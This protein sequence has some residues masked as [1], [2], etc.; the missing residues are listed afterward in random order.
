[1]RAVFSSLLLFSLFSIN[2]AQEDLGVISQARVINVSSYYQ[3]WEMANTS[4]INEFS[5]PIFLYLPFGYAF[6]I[7]AHANFAKI[8]GDNVQ[9]ISGFTDTQIALNYHFENANLLFT[10]GINLPS[11]KKQLTLN[12]FLSSS[13]ISYSVFRFH[14]PNFGE[15]VGI[16][17]GF[18]WAL[19]LSD[20]V[21]AGI[22]ATYQLKEG[23]KPLETFSDE[24]DPGDEILLT[25]GMDFR[26]NNTT[27]LSTDV[28]FTNFNTDKIGENEIFSSGNKWVFNLQFR[29]NINFNE[30]WLFARYRSRSKNQLV[31]AGMLIDEQEKTTP[32]QVDVMAHY[33][34]RFRQTMYFRILAEARFFQDTSSDFSGARLF[35]LG[36]MPEFSLSRNVMLPVRFLFFSGNLKNK[37]DLNGFEAGL[38]L[39]MSF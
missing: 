15:G 20:N 19:P 23:F 17:P 28:I 1:M 30:L 11:G 10:L 22:G 7:T 6:N 12:E 26:L 29:K 8:T 27:S 39:T 36:I 5:T 31:Q 35:G 18:T 4:N 16:A 2:Y 33:R 14:V 13:L 9:G 32:N 34:M 38:A 24:Y 37:V 3:S 25:A 21:V